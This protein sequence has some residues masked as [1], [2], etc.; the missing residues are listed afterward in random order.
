MT[1]HFKFYTFHDQFFIADALS[2]SQVFWSDEEHSVRLATNHGIISMAMNTDEDTVE[3]DLKILDEEEFDMSTDVYDYIVEGDIEIASGKVQL[4]SCPSNSNELTVDI[5]PGR[6]R[7]R[8]S[9]T[10]NNNIDDI[11]FRCNIQMRLTDVI[12]STKIVKN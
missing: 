6:Y 7:V 1:H 8:I 9:V 3:G 5:R 11:I 2:D 4:R 10:P 12:A